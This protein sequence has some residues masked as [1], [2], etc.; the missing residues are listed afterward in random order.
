VVAQFSAQGV[1]NAELTLS[2]PFATTVSAAVS[3][4]LKKVGPAIVMLHSQ[5][6]QFGDG[7]VGLSPELIKMVIH[8]ESNCRFG[9]PFTQAQL[10]GYS[11]VPSVLYVHGDNV[12]GNPAPTGQ[13]RLDFCTNDMNAINANG[14]QATLVQLPDV[15]MTGNNHMLMQDRNNL[16]IADWLIGEITKRGL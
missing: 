11:Q 14:G 5:G 6:G 2:P 13:P 10:D 3:E 7:A 9:T 1:P 16:E 8:V 15:G 12:V 4:L